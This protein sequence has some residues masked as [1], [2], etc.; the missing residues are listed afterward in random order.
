MQITSASDM[1]GDDIRAKS[2]IKM[3]IEQREYIAVVTGFEHYQGNI[4]RVVAILD[5]DGTEVKAFSDSV[6]RFR[7]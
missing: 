2:K 5:D 7:S 3:W 4:V 6:V 1:N